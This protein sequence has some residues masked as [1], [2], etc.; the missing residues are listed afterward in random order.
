MP[1]RSWVPLCP[2]HIDAA[3]E[4]IDDPSLARTHTRGEEICVQKAIPGDGG[5]EFVQ[6]P[7]R[8]NLRQRG[9]ESADSVSIMVPMRACQRGK[10]STP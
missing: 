4:S 6:F 8:I 9:L 5:L 2:G 3:N 10:K 7:G 1:G